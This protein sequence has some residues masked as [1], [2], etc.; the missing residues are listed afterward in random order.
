[1]IKNTVLDAIAWLL[2][3]I[4]IIFTLW[5]IFGSSPVETTIMFSILSLLL[6]KV[7]RISNEFSYFRGDYAGFK[8]NT[9]ESFQ[10]VKEHNQKVE[11][12][13]KDIK[14]MLIRRYHGG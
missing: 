4:T 14:K 8:E 11:A 10:R 13:L 5:Y 7:W 12:E 2:L 1:M 3:G 9:K 6:V